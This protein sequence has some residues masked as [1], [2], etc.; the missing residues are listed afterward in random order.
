[1]ILISIKLLRKLVGHIVCYSLHTSYS[2]D[3]EFSSCVKEGSG[4]GKEVL[5]VLSL[6]H[7]K[8]SIQCVM[9]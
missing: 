3:L 8:Q 4:H 7:F 2:F 9:L 6:Q 5:M 1:M